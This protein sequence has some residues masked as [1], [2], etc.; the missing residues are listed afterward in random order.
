VNSE[1]L[2][3]IEGDKGL[4]P[5]IRQKNSTLFK[6]FSLWKTVLKANSFF[7]YHF[8]HSNQNRVAANFYKN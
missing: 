7:M 6:P 4:L 3:D 1:K 8:F 5:L 2:K